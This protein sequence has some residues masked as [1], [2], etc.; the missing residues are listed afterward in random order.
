[1]NIVCICSGKYRI[2]FS[3]TSAITVYQVWG[4]D[5]WRRVIFD[6]PP[7]KL[8]KLFQKNKILPTASICLDGRGYAFVVEDVRYCDGGIV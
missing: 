4:K 3:K 1:M 7:E 8:V 2:S 6:I 5:D